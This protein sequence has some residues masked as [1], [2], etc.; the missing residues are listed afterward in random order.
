M[1]AAGMAQPGL[2][3]RFHFI[4]SLTASLRPTPLLMFGAATLF[5]VGSYHI[6]KERAYLGA[7]AALG[8]RVHCTPAKHRV[9]GRARTSACF[10]AEEPR[11]GGRQRQAV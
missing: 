10:L 3:W 5:V 11:G 7:A 4:S 8:W 9:G 2:T 1:A 6:G